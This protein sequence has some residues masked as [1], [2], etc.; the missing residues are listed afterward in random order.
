M[1]SD[2]VDIVLK[3]PMSLGDAMHNLEIALEFCY[4]RLF[5]EHDVSGFMDFLTVDDFI[6]C[7]EEMRQNFHAFYAF[8]FFCLELDAVEGLVKPR[9]EDFTWN[10]LLMSYITQL[11]CDK[12][13]L[14]SAR[15]PHFPLDFAAHDVTYSRTVKNL[16]HLSPGRSYTSA[17]NLPA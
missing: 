8:L 4:E 10:C 11:I 13:D 9:G 15:T 12:S 2:F 7:R 5:P 3:D 6:Q 16:N 17:H 14:L 1:F